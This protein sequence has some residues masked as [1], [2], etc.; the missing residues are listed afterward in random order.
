[1]IHNGKR[2]TQTVIPKL[3]RDRKAVAHSALFL[4]VLLAS[5]DERV[6]DKER[7]AILETMHERLGNAFDSIRAGDLADSVKERQLRILGEAKAIAAKTLEGG[8]VTRAALL[9]FV[10]K[11]NPDLAENAREAGAAQLDA[12][13]AQVG[14]WRKSLTPEEWKSLRVVVIGAQMPR[15][16]NLQTQYF[17]RLLGEKGE[18]RR[19]VYPESLWEEPKALNLLA[20]HAVDENVSVAFFDNPDRMEID[21]MA[22]VAA[23]HIKRMK[24]EE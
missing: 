18:S 13:H 22:D 5:P 12:L 20:T 17:A 21:L 19:L 3:Y 2:D 6:I 24:F 15:G 11:V 16:R 8:K 4:W 7:R 9:A 23:A 1:M 10:A 14:A